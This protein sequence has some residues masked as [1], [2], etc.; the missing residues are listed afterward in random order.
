MS[1]RRVRRLALLGTGVLLVALSACSNKI[2]DTPAPAV[3]AKLTAAVPDHLS[4]GV[5]VSVTSAPGEGAEWRDAA[6]GARVA[7]DRFVLGGAKV[8]LVPVNDKGTEAGA[9]AAVKTLADDGVAGIVVAT[10]GGHVRGAL[11]EAATRH[12]PVLLPY[13]ATTEA[14]PDDAWLTGPESAITDQRL[15][16]ALHDRS[17]TKPYLMDAG[18]GAVEGLAPIV[19]RTFAAGDDPAELARTL[20]RRQKK[21]T[22]ADAVVIS[23]PAELQGR[24]VSA[25]QGAGIDLPTV[26]TPDALSP[27]FPQAIVRADGS[28]SGT[29]VSAGL[30]EGDARA[31]EPTESGRALA[32]YF[33]ALN[34]T[35]ENTAATDL[36]G[37]RPFTAVAGAADVRSHDA[38]VA[39]VRAAAKAGSA[40]PAEV[41]RALAGM[42]LGRTDG[43]AGAPLDFSA[44]VAVADDDV[45]PLAATP[46]SPG[47]RPPAGDSAATPQPGSS[48]SP[49]AKGDTAALFWY[50]A[51]PG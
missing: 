10:A 7:I 24:L 28:L 33:T 12:L 37:E 11:Q 3:T 23:G 17:L 32:A 46:T 9:A 50:S 19:S 20:A 4:V 27:R 51:A 18:R 13:E 6:E 15:V 16:E 30:D 34:L 41:G 1:G 48:Q 40:D 31:L 43:L 39:L 35:A 8:T 49:D 25:L 2:T 26:L 29:F 5:V 42:H 38:V 21:G 44:P 36:F 22:A 45:R 47:V 14:L